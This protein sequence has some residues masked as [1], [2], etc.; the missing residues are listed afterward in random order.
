MG[1]KLYDD[2]EMARASGVP[3]PSLRVL[4]AARA[5]ESTKVAKEH[6]GFRRM[7]AHQEA[8][9][10]AVAGALCEHF[11][12]NIRLTASVMGLIEPDVWT[13]LLLASDAC[14]EDTGPPKGNMIGATKEDWFAELVDRKFLFLRVPEVM[15]LQFTLGAE[16]REGELLLGVV[17]KDSFTLIPWGLDSPAAAAALRKKSRPEIAERAIRFHHLALV[18]RQNFLS[19]ATINLSMQARAASERLKGRNVRFVQ[20]LVQTKKEA[21]AN[22]QSGR[23]SRIR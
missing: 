3:V 8:L 4:Q 12:W 10:A 11:A 20:D 9:K 5:I 23:R 21:P 14:E 13:V 17:G 22:D 19:K 6:G 2:K 16:Y 18:A 15:K 1:A 7:W